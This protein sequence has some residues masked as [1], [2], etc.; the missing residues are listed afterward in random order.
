MNENIFSVSIII[1]AKNEQEILPLCLEAIN[2]L[3]YPD[4]KVETIVI[5]NGSTDN[6]ATIAERYGAK[7]V[8]HPVGNIASA[9]N[10]GAERANGEILA[11]VDADCLVDS[12][13]LKNAIKNFGN[14]TVGCV[15]SRPGVPESNTTWVQRLW[16]LMKVKKGLS[17]VEWLASSNFIVRKRL[18]EDVLGFDE[19]LD[20]CED[21]DIGLRLSKKCTLIYD[22]KVKSTHLRDPR[23]L[24][25]FFKKEIWHGRGNLKGFFKHGII[26]SE[27]PSV[28]IP[29]VYLFC[30]LV[31]PLSL[32]LFIQTNVSKF[33]F[34]NVVI[35]IIF[36]L[37]YTI[38]TCMKEKSVKNLPGLFLLSTVYLVARSIA[39]LWL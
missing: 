39:L 14:K 26:V 25:E 16:S 29:I 11:F 32:Y 23:T 18:F 15:G 20:T 3:D 35:L 5:D 27:L 6:T 33:L 8:S 31:M 38:R 17:K 30:I 4:D 21:V 34:L 10:A 28:V 24:S 2:N 9:R 13:W 22:D 7:V 36:P 19:A 12:E 1:P 37:L